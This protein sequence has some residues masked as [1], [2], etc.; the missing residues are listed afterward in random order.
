[1]PTL[2]CARCGATFDLTDAHTEL[3]RRDF[4]GMPR[5]PRQEYLCEECWRAYVEDFLG[6][7]FEL[8]VE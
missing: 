6:E 8:L 2:E 1:M 5:S 3:V 7:E 4:V